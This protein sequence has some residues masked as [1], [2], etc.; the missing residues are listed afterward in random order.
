MTQKIEKEIN[1]AKQDLIRRID[2]NQKT[3]KGGKARNDRAAVSS[4]GQN[5][6]IL[7]RRGAEVI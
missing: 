6:D 4:R 7:S 3:E 1:K 2:Q 5:I